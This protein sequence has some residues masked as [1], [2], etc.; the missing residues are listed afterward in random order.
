MVKVRPF[1]NID[2]Y[3]RRYRGESTGNPS[4]GWYVCSIDN[5]YEVRREREREKGRGERDF[6][7]F[8]FNWEGYS[9]SVLSHSTVNAVWRG[10]IISLCHLSVC[11]TWEEQ[12]YSAFNSC[13]F[14][15]AGVH[16][17][18][19]LYKVLMKYWSSKCLCYLGSLGDLPPFEREN[20]LLN[21]WRGL[22]FLSRERGKT[23]ELLNIPWF[24][25]LGI[26]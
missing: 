16:F 17:V 5:I 11:W 8:F 21:I 4:V 20:I 26:F 15:T 6:F 2:I 24:Y 25:S 14:R 19:S 10:W 9:D 22:V 23:S 13:V 12:V 1:R 7:F 3:A 18:I